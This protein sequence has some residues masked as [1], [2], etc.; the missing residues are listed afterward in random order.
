MNP[1]NSTLLQNMRCVWRIIYT[2]IQ[3]PPC[4]ALYVMIDTKKHALLAV[5]Q[6]EKS[7]NWDISSSDSVS[8]FNYINVVESAETVGEKNC[9]AILKYGVRGKKQAA[10]IKPRRQ[11]CQRPNSQTSHDVTDD[12]DQPSGGSRPAAVAVGNA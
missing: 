6:G 3:P 8:A 1:R 10:S 9:A 11:H 7:P 4:V 2:I 12:D 5:T